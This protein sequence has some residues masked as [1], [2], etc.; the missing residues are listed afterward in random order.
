MEPRRKP[1]H[2]IIGNMQRMPASEPIYMDIDPTIHEKTKRVRD[3]LPQT[4][5]RG[6][7]M[8]SYGGEKTS[9]SPSRLKSL[10]C[11]PSTEVNDN[12]AES[13]PVSST[14]RTP[15][16]SQNYGNV[17]YV[18]PYVSSVAR[19]YR[20]PGGMFPT[21]SATSRSGTRTTYQPQSSRRKTSNQYDERPLRESYHAPNEGLI[22]F[23]D[24]IYPLRN[25]F[26][27]HT[28]LP[29]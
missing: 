23:C 14:P 12:T 10:G 17:P 11:P 9:Q 1:Q 21:Q 7:S 6:S 3:S 8:P 16:S 29:K 26:A 18:S 4:S 25:S 24:T 19:D 28:K 20:V 27:S 2:Q 15:P 13:R 5:A 22:M